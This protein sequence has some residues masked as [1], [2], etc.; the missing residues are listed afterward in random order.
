MDRKTALSEAEYH[1]K[2]ETVR[3]LV[4]EAMQATD[5]HQGFAQHIQAARNMYS[6]S[7]MNLYHTLGVHEAETRASMASETAARLMITKSIEHNAEYMAPLS[8]NLEIVDVNGVLARAVGGEGCVIAGFHIGPYWSIVPVLVRYNCNFSILFPPALESQR[9]LIKKVIEANLSYY[10][11]RSEYDFIDILE[12]GFVFKMKR[13]LKSGRCVLVYPDGF[14][15]YKA[16][17]NDGNDI[18]IRLHRTEL[19]VKTTIARLA[20]HSGK[21]IILF[22]AHYGR[23]LERKIVLEEVS[24]PDPSM[25]PQPDERNGVHETENMFGTL[26]RLLVSAP[27]EWEGWCYINTF[28]S[29]A[30]IE[31]IRANES[32][33]SERFQDRYFIMNRGEKYTTVLDK[34]RVSI[35]RV[36]NSSSDDLV[37]A[38]G[39]MGSQ[40]AVAAFR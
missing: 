9:P 14:G 40:S 11:S 7:D 15:G 17:Q 28:Y 8:N 37:G 18:N 24:G 16:N 22:H 23:G 39:N 34:V 27:T 4:K 38:Y 33:N 19:T 3:R 25:I 10:L 30:E 21:P 2:T 13:A 35:R 31:C 1:E 20:K 32:K 29:A 5:D 6:F 26:E 36:P 12:K